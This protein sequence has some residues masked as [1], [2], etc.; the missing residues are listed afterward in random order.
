MFE[1]WGGMRSCRHQPCFCG[2][3]SGK[4]LKSWF[5]EIKPS[6]AHL[7]KPTWLSCLSTRFTHT[8]TCTSPIIRSTHS[9]ALCL[10]FSFSLTYLSFSHSLENAQWQSQSEC[11]L[12]LKNSSRKQKRSVRLFFVVLDHHDPDASQKCDNT[13]HQALRSIERLGLFLLS[14]SSCSHALVLASDSIM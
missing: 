7:H 8:H 4:P 11:T 13:P 5:R 3:S 1:F 9:L 10:F 14:T 6:T 12:S 2:Q